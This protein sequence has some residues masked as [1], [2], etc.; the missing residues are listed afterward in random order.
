MDQDHTYHYGILYL[1]HLIISADGI[2]DAGELR[3]LETII[4]TEGM[5]A[6]I[7]RKFIEETGDMSE[8]EI[9][10]RGID[11]ISTCSREQMVRA[12]GWLMKI[13]ESDGHIH[14]KEIRF[15]L[16]S[17]KKAG[18]GF[19]EVVSEAKKLPAIP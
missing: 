19:N 3:A 16:Y 14:A 7:Y 12:F 6:D 15:L 1:I 5:D 8:K 4:E 18:I 11:L 2:I 13:S 10:H 17:V 9:F